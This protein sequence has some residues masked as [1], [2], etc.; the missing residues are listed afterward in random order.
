VLPH[1]HAL[2]SLDRREHHQV[3][4]LVHAP[5]HQRGHGLGLR[6]QRLGG[7]LAQ[8]LSPHHHHHHHYYPP[9]LPHHHHAPDS[10]P[11]S[12]I[13]I[14]IIIIIMMPRRSKV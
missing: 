7:H 8:H 1:R 10:L 3:A 4:A 13:I 14:I 12:A 9:P 2:H 5:P 11:S 6:R